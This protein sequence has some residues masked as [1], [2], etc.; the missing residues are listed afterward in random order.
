M[1]RALKPA[2]N[3]TQNSTL[4]RPIRSFAVY[5]Q[6]G[7]TLIELLI[8]LAVSA[9]I[10]ALAYQAVNGMVKVQTGMQAHTERSAQVQRAFWWLE[11]DFIQM[12]PR[13]VLDGY[14]SSL[15]A[16]QYRADLGVELTR[17]AQFATPNA[18]GGLVRVGYVLQGDTLVRLVWPV[19][20][21]APDTQPSKQVVLSGVKSMTVRFLQNLPNASDS[22]EPWLALWPPT[23]TGD[24]ANTAELTTSQAALTL[25]PTL[26]EVQIELDDLGLITRLFMGVDAVEWGAPPVL[27]PQAPQ[28]DDNAEQTTTEQTTAE[29]LTT[30]QTSPDGLVIEQ[31]NPVVE[32]PVTTP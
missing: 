16:L 10:A 6:Q 3:S 22:V 14:G 8:A 27:A 9:V 26:V 21:R 19:L 13:A 12:V 7:F 28:T 32:T 5:A 31:S 24:A 4:K 2:L 1:R 20:D 29:Q 23:W 11:Q 15:P 18:S 17:A 30:E 25:L